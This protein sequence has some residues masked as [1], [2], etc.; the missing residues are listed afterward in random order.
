MF[1]VIIAASGKSSRVGAK[2][3]KLLMY[4]NGRTV[5]ENSIL[6]FLQFNQLG[7]IIVA[8]STEIFDTTSKLL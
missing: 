5:I 3:N 4:V 8:T 7:K 6:P 2:I 1:D